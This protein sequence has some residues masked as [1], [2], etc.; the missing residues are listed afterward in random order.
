MHWLAIIVLGLASSLDNLG[1]GLTYGLRGKRISVLSNGVIT[2][3]AMLLSFVSLYIGKSVNCVIPITAANAI[4]GAIITLIGLWT[5]GMTIYQKPQ[6]S[7]TEV[8]THPDKVDKDHNDVIS[9]SEAAVLGLALSLNAIGT[10]FGA[11]VTGLNPILTTLAIGVFSF[12][13]IESGVRFGMRMNRSSVGKY[14]S[15]LSGLFLIII[16]IREILI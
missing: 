12:F 2:V 9:I 8:M 7:L 10:A 6:S 14:T 4:G 1:I 3:I 11:G 5:I 13:S 15:L 16:G